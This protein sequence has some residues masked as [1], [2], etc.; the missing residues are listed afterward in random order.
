RMLSVEEQL[1]SY[2]PWGERKRT[3]NDP[4]DSVEDLFRANCDAGDELRDRRR[5][6][7]T[8]EHIPQL[9]DYVGSL[10]EARVSVLAITDGW[11]L[12]VPD[13]RLIPG[14]SPPPPAPVG[15]TSAGQLV[16]ITS[17]NAY[18]SDQACASEKARLALLDDNQKFKDLIALANK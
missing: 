1:S 14:G 5:E 10:R 16:P 7:N 11:R 9:I 2:W 13:N 4:D 15:V 17:I 12:F 3:T 8:L 6:E 18:P